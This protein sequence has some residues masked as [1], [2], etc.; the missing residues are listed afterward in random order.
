M[1]VRNTKNFFAAKELR[2]DQS[3]KKNQRPHQTVDEGM[4]KFKLNTL[5]NR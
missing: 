3:C 2:L 5:N 1:A 4:L